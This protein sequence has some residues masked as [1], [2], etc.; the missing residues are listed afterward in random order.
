MVDL[1]NDYF[2]FSGLKA[3]IDCTKLYTLCNGDAECC[4]DHRRILKNLQ[5]SNTN[6]THLLEVC[7]DNVGPIQIGTGHFGNN[8]SE[9]AQR[10]AQNLNLPSM[11]QILT[12][13][14]PTFDYIPK[15]AINAITQLWTTILHELCDQPTNLE[16]WLSHFMFTKTILR[17]PIREGTQHATLFA[18]R[19]VDHC[20]Q[21]L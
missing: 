10:L 18:T 20:V 12:G 15:D 9:S 16:R 3:C 11:E 4:R 19:I 8:S 13:S 5:Q 6:L 14:L 7:R 17:T 2:L 21:C 1:T